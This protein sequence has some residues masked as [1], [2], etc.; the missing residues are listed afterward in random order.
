M[1][2]ACKENDRLRVLI[3][4]KVVNF[5]THFAV[6]IEND[7]QIAS[8]IN[9]MKHMTTMSTLSHHYLLRQFPFLFDEKSHFSM[10]IRRRLR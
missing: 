6:E 2:V 7:L 1:S 8:D 9:V 4:L 3:K 10:S 5:Q